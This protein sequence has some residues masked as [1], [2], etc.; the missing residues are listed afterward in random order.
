[1]EEVRLFDS[2]KDFRT[3]YCCNPGYVFEGGA[4]EVMRYPVASVESHYASCAYVFV[5][6]FHEWI[7][8][9]VPQVSTVAE[10][11]KEQL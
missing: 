1:M 8:G 2:G 7:Q 11:S 3:E 6:G 10:R 5:P 9:S 4:V